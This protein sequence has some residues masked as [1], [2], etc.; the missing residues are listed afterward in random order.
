VADAC[1]AF[2]KP[3]FNGLQRSAEEVHAMSLAN[4]QGEYAQVLQANSLLRELSLN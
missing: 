3:D 1:F 4:L 2:A